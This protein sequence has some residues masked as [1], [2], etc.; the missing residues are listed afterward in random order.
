MFPP[1]PS[2]AS[3]P[4]LVQVV[5]EPLLDDFQYW[6]EQT[7]SLLTS[8]QADCLAEAECQAL[9]SQIEMAQKEVATARTLLAATEGKAGVETSVVLGWHQLVARGWQVARF[10][11]QHQ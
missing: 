4:S 7:R 5:L 9:T 6:F 1:Q 3:D 8:P 2:D 11:R 10:V